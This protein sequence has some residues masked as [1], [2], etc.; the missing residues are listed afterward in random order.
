VRLPLE[1]IPCGVFGYQPHMPESIDRSI[2]VENLTRDYGE[3]RAVDCVDIDVE[4]GQIYGFLGPNGAGK[5][6]VIQVMATILAPTKGQVTL[7]GY[8]VCTQGQQVRQSIGVA[9]QDVGI[10]PLMTGRELL[11]LQAELFGATGRDAQRIASE[12]L[13]TVGLADVDPK[14]RTGQYSGGMKRRLDL[15]LALV[16]EPKVLFLDEPTT[17][18][19]PASRVAIWDEVRRLNEERGIT[20]FLTT[21]YLEEADKLADKIGIINKG[22]IVLEGSPDELKRKIGATAITLSFHSPEDAERAESALVAIAPNRRLA[23]SELVTYFSDG[24]NVVPEIVRTLD[25]S[26]VALTGL[27]ISEPSLDDVFLNITGERL[28]V[29]SATASAGA[30]AEQS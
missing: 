30:G 11:E 27:G 10:D 15:A 19:D 2:H 28:E 9:L 21:Q 18:L 3:L 24:G 23:G 13:S 26:D 1:A 12:L 14:K 7:A 6:T 20:I 29:G 4:S 17:G 25:A 22:R 5:S 8:D 16:H